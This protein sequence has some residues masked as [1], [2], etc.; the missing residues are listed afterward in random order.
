MIT[1]NIYYIMV[2]SPSDVVDIAKVAIECIQ[3]WNILNSKDR[4]IALVPLHWSF[5]AYPSM[6]GSAQDVIN[7][8]V[9]NSSDA[10][11]TVFGSRIGT[12]TDNYISGTVEEIEIMRK[13][14]K[15]V[16]VFFCSEIKATK[17]NKQVEE[18]EKY[19]K[20]FQGLYSTYSDEN[21]F[22]QLFSQKLNKLVQDKLLKESNDTEK[23]E[24]SK[25]DIQFSDKEISII[26]KWCYS[27]N[28]LFLKTHTTQKGIKYTFGDYYYIAKDIK[29]V[30]AKDDFVNRLEKAG[31]LKMSEGKD[32]EGR[33]SDLAKKDFLKGHANSNISKV[34]HWQPRSNT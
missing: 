14:G 3:N 31:Y 17:N 7:R 1:G 20:S 11:I 22:R 18:L 26:R 6:D 33:L 28:D 13:S 4:R 34:I 9:V 10:L 12:P 16:M 23:Q 25:P 32:N 2:G 8:Q 30:V 15:P 19:Q 5:S 27:R 24:E 21:D 29:E